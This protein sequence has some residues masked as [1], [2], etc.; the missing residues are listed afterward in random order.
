MLLVNTAHRFWQCRCAPA[1]MTKEAGSLVGRIENHLNTPTSRIRKCIHNPSY[2]ALAT[3][4]QVAQKRSPSGSFFCILC[5]AERW[6]CNGNIGKIATYPM[7]FRTPSVVPV[8]V[9]KTCP[10]SNKHDIIKGFTT[11]FSAEDDWPRKPQPRR[12]PRK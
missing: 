5:C 11:F 1:R 2:V 10:K 12:A 7:R 6:W 3:S 4:G 9:E 8:F